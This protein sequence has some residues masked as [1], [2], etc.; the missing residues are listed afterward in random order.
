MDGVE[1]IAVAVRDVDAMIEHDASGL[2]DRLAR[3]KARI[4]QG[5]RP[6]SGEIGEFD[7]F[8]IDCVDIVME[9]KEVSRHIGG[10]LDRG[11]GSGAKPRLR[12]S[13]AG[14][15]FNQFPIERDSQDYLC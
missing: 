4:M 8:L 5:D 14:D 12:N 1:D 9:M 3:R 10:A 15:G 13:T 7:A 11:L 2:L 6:S